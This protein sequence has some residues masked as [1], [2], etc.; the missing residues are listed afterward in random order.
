M[1]K[2]NK[3]AER[4]K[5]L[6]KWLKLA[7]VFSVSL[8]AVALLIYVLRPAKT[9]SVFEACYEECQKLGLPAENG[10]CDSGYYLSKRTETMG[11]FK[12]GDPWCYKNAGSCLIFCKQE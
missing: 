4:G 11:E 6:D 8:I 10:R 5:E 1:T 9:K 2:E 7:L 3:D 12:K